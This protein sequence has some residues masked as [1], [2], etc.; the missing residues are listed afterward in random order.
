MLRESKNEVV[1]KFERRRN[2]ATQIL[3]IAASSIAST[4]RKAYHLFPAIAAVEIEVSAWAYGEEQKAVIS[5]ATELGISVFAYSQLGNGF[6]TGTIRIFNYSAFPRVL[7][8]VEGDH[9]ARWNCFKEENFRANQAIVEGLKTIAE[10]SGITTAQLCLAWVASLGPTMIHLAGS[11]KAIRTLENLQAGEVQL[12]AEE[13]KTID[14]V[15]IAHPVSGER[16]FGGAANERLQ[17]W[18]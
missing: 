16:Y 4:S 12:T 10:K 8:D 7:I 11:S 5:T 9:R 15:L 13:R 6:L 14:E 1:Q 18:G 2:V 3:V 17:L